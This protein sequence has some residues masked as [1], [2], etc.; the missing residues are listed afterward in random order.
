MTRRAL[1]VRASLTVIALT[2]AAFA[3][4]EK[5]HH[6]ITAM[7]ARLLAPGSTDAANPNGLPGVPDWFLAGI[8]DDAAQ[9]SLDPDNFKNRA[10][11][12]LDSTE[13]P[14]HY[15]DYE[16]LEAMGVPPGVMPRFR[17]DYYKLCYEHQL[18][19]RKIGVLPWAVA[20]WQQRLTLAFAEHRKWPNNAT[21]RRKCLV[22]AGLMSHYAG[23]L[24]MPLHTTMHHDGRVKTHNDRSPRSGIHAKVDGLFRTFDYDPRK[25]LDGAQA[26]VYGD[27]WAA[28]REE[29]DRSHALV[30][31]V[32][33]LADKLPP[34]NGHTD[35]ADVIAFGAE[36]M[37]AGVTFIA[38]LY[39]TAWV[40]SADVKLPDWLDREALTLPH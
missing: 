36:R 29:F 16:S 30:D 40:K 23:D 35:D 31:R 38:S 12:Q 26:E 10:M 19:P 34:R 39:R 4:H 1:I 2:T 6:A 8:A 32:Y 25:V 37:K 9:D 5:E 24:C 14:E 13:P 21:I 20:E 33:E 22:Y 7:S 17:Y 28:I 15:L 18:D 3:W 27:V 11:P